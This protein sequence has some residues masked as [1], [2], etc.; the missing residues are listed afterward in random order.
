MPG[1]VGHPLLGCGVAVLASSV[2]GPQWPQGRL[3]HSCS[4]ASATSRS[5]SESWFWLW[6]WLPF[7][8]DYFQ[9]LVLNLPS[10]FVTKP[11]AVQYFLFCFKLAKAAFCCL[12]VMALN[13]HSLPSACL[14][15]IP[16]L[17]NSWRG[18]SFFFAL[19]GQKTPGKRASF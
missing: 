1:W 13:W 7:A 17:S 9:K 6:F 3:Q 4:L 15:I 18:S 10:Y 8:H 2:R 5:G 14:T 11:V 19:H 16:F 12:Q